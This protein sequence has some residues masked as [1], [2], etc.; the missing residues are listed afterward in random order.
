MRGEDMLKRF[1]KE[2]SGATAFVFAIAA[3][4]FI[5]GR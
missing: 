5:G 1:L 4:V 3:P 2:E